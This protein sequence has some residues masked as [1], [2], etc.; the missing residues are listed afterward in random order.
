MFHVTEHYNWQRVKNIAICDV[1][2]CSP[3]I[4][5]LVSQNNITNW[6]Y[7][8]NISICKALFYPEDG[9]TGLPVKY[10]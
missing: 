10:C 8:K 5:S 1:I 9:G 2:P 3:L 7:V 4:I 6:P